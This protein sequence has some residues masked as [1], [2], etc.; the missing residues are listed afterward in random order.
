MKSDYNTLE[1]FKHT[2]SPY[3]TWCFE[4][5]GTLGYELHQYRKNFLKRKNINCYKKTHKETPI[6]LDKLINKF[7]RKIKGLP[8]FTDEVK[9]EYF[10][11]LQNI[12]NLYYDETFNPKLSRRCAYYNYLAENYCLYGKNYKSK[13]FK[14]FVSSG[15]AKYYR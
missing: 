12:F 5:V 10:K 2:R 6:L 9:Y 14:E 1:V 8:I 13:S 4:N 3:E 7:D 11:G 15:L